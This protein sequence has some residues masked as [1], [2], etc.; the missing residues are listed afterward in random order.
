M[1]RLVGRYRRSKNRKLKLVAD[2]PLRQLTLT[3]TLNN[4]FHHFC[5]NDA[6]IATGS[7]HTAK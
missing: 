1:Q 3:L 2:T 7:K 6:Q 5:T 4:N